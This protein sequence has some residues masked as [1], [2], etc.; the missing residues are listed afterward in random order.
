MNHVTGHVVLSDKAKKRERV[1]EV[2][3]QKVKHSP[4]FPSIQTQLIERERERETGKGEEEQMEKV[5]NAEQ[6]GR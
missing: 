3:A 5:A 1:R 6:T 4:Q 2:A